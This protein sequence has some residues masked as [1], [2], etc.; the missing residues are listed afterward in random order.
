MK[1][2]KYIYIYDNVLKTKQV[3]DIGMSSKDK[4]GKHISRNKIPENIV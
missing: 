2:L 1:T 3:S 4:R